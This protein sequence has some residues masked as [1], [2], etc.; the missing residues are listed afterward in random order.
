MLYQLMRR[1]Q[2]SKVRKYAGVSHSAFCVLYARADRKC[3]ASVRRFVDGQSVP[4][5][6]KYFTIALITYSSVSPVVS[7]TGRR[8]APAGTSAPFLPSC[9]RG[10][11][12]PGST[13]TVFAKLVLVFLSNRNHTPVRHLAGHVFELDGGVVNAEVREQSLSDLAQDAFA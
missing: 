5:S 9:L 1:P 4:S 7:L 3:L 12:A 2:L 6:R 8:H 11:R 10:P 13:G